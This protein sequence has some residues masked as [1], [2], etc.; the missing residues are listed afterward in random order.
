M[1]TSSRRSCPGVNLMSSGSTRRRREL[2]HRV[3]AG[4]DVTLYWSTPDD[5]TSVVVCIHATEE[6]MEFTV[7]GERSLDAFYH[8]FA[9]L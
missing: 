4:L 7:A 8:P 9:Y 6:V 3:S 1:S 2:A 5:R